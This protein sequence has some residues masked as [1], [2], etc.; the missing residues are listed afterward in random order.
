MKRLFERAAF[1]LVERKA[2]VASDGA[3]H[4]SI[5]RL[6]EL[7]ASLAWYPGLCSPGLYAVARYA[8][9]NS[10]VFLTLNFLTP[11]A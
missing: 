8:S 7:C 5:A 9:L 4:S 3:W 6:R 11:L 2:R 10:A 1:N